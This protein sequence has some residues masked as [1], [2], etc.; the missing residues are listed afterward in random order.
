MVRSRAEKE[1]IELSLQS[2]EQPVMLS[3]DKTA[4]MAAFVSILE[5]GMDACKETRKKSWIRFSALRKGTNIVFTIKDN[6]K[7]IEESKKDQIFNLF[8]S[9]KGDEGTGFGLF[10]AH[11]S[12]KQHGG[13][14]TVNSRPGKYTEFVI[15]LP[16]NCPAV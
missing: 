15:T 7:G 5:N 12:V 8:Y 10:I 1:D 4:L 2:L 6:G 9:E 3:I 11:R 14:I 16:L 13:T